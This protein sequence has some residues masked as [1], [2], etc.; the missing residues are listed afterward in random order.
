MLNF[1]YTI[2]FLQVPNF[3]G[4]STEKLRGEHRKQAARVHEAALLPPPPFSFVLPGTEMRRHRGR[5]EE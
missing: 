5:K 3:R 2:R 1:N 4:G